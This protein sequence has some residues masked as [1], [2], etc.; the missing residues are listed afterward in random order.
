[1]MMTIVLH[2]AYNVIVHH[3]MF[4]YNIFMCTL[5]RLVISLLIIIIVFIIRRCTELMLKYFTGGKMHFGF[6][7]SDVQRAKELFSALH[8]FTHT[9][10]GK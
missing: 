10:E 9:H 7:E 5:L 8:T 4:V 3:V 6:K 2:L 1:M